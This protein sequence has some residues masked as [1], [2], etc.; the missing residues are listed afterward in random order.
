MTNPVIRRVSTVPG[1]PREVAVDPANTYKEA[2]E[3][4]G[5]ELN[6]YK[7]FVSGQEV[8]ATDTVGSATTPIFLMHQIKGNA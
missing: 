3:A 4:A 2:L 8:S 5:F 7:I 6:G 1:N